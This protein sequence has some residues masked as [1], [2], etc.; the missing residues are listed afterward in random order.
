MG[1]PRYSLDLCSIFTITFFS[2]FSSITVTRNP[3]ETAPKCSLYRPEKG[4]VFDMVVVQFSVMS[5]LESC[6]KER[7][8][9]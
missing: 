5:T 7:F 4:S 3:A 9:S 8:K 1:Y 6:P 2:C